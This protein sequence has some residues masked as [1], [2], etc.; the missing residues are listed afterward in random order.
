MVNRIKKVR[1]RTGETV[2]FDSGKIEA[3]IEKALKD[4]DLYAVAL[5]ERLVRDENIPFGKAHDIVGKKIA[6]RQIK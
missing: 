3:A 6:K 5:T 4:E 2:P 1:K